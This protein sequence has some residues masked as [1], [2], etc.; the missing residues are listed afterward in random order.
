MCGLVEPGECGQWAGEDG[1]LWGGELACCWMWVL[2]GGAP[3][4]RHTWVSLGICHL[5]F[6][7]SDH[8]HSGSKHACFSSHSFCGQFSAWGLS[9]IS[10]IWAVISSENQEPLPGHVVIGKMHLFMEQEGDPHTL[11][12]CQLGAGQLLTSWPP[13]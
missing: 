4:C 9:R 5:C 2:S 8:K 7:T 6:V 3:G 12:G 13:P 10:S 1:G 11:E